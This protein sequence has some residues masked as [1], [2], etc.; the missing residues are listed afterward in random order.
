MSM[1]KIRAASQILAQ[2][3][4]DGFPLTT[5]PPMPGKSKSGVQI[6]IED[7]AGGIIDEVTDY[8]DGE[9]GTD[10]I[11]NSLS[12]DGVPRRIAGVWAMATDLLTQTQGDARYATAIQLSTVQAVL[13][14][15][16]DAKQDASDTLTDI[17]GAAAGGAL[18]YLK[19]I[20]ADI[21]AVIASVPWADLSGVP[22]VTA[23]TGL[24][25]GGSL[26]ASIALAVAFAGSGVAATVARSDH[27]HA[28]TY[29]ADAPYDSALYGRRGGA[30]EALSAAALAWTGSAGAIQM[31]NGSTVAGV[32][33]WAVLGS[34]GASANPVWVTGIGADGSVGSATQV[35]VLEFN[36][37]GILT[38]VSFATIT[39]GAIGAAPAFSSA[40]AN[41]FWAT[42]SGASGAPSL[43]AIVAPDI[44]S[45][46][47]SKTTTGIFSTAR[48]GSGTASSATWLRG[49][50][51]WS[52]LSTSSVSEGSNLYYTDARARA[53]ISG[54]SPISYSSSTGVISH[55]ATDGWLHVPATSTT[56]NGRVLMAGSTAGS[57]AWTALSTSNISGLTGWATKAYTNGSTTDVAEGSRLYYT[58]ARAQAAVAGLYL[59][60]SGTAV[61]SSALGGV[62]S[63]YFVQGSG[64]GALGHR[65][66]NVAAFNVAFQSGFYDSSAATDGPQGA[67]WTHM[68]RS[69][70]TGGGVGN[71]WSLDLAAP[72]AGGTGGTEA[73][74]MRLVTAS[75]YGTW[76]RL[77]H[78]GNLS[79]ST[80]PGGP[81][82]PLSGG[83]VSG[84]TTFNSGISLDAPITI[85]TGNFL[86]LVGTGYV[87]KAGNG[88]D[89]DNAILTFQGSTTGAAFRFDGRSQFN[90]TAEFTNSDPA[91]N[92]GIALDAANVRVGGMTQVAPHLYTASYILPVMAPKT[93][94]FLVHDSTLSATLY[95]QTNS[96][97]RV[98]VRSGAVTTTTL[99]NSN[100]G[101]A[102]GV[103]PFNYTTCILVGPTVSGSI[104]C[105]LILF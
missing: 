47:T 67:V 45:I 41:L 83:I 103:I 72:F 54:T 92:N 43:R 87:M 91:Y 39:P 80:L 26:V 95:W 70:H 100:V 6:M 90:R 34:Y 4:V 60:A 18:G 20:A 74:Y 53:A 27:D 19:R 17:V 62:G 24:T 65:T 44:P 66:T 25:G 88:T 96:A 14:N 5:V 101:D 12:G 28:G 82:L 81:Y 59:G 50:G 3:E 58:D 68:V 48:L 38:G 86:A 49:D 56:N 75:G 85:G 55:L 8:Y 64:S 102:N 29:L 57:F 77:W 51:S 104:Y 31:A 36:R 37:Y 16:I 30:W 89:W 99:E 7:I 105:S 9:T 63:D 98:R 42:P 11:L 23:G 69:M 22:S 71:H 46:D 78:D 52:T 35:P 84:L 10:S 93:W 33:Q 1:N 79:A 32:A 76:R 40:S 94:C 13:Q 61:N 15:A 97:Q 21:W 2:M 73:Y